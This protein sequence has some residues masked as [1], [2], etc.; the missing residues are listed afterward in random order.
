MSIACPRCTEK[1]L[2]MLMKG[3]DKNKNIIGVLKCAKCNFIFDNLAE[4]EGSDD[5]TENT[6]E[7]KDNMDTFDMT[8]FM[9]PLPLYCKVWYSSSTGGD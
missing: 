8:R 4:E 3:T 6:V 2:V 1:E 9:Y 5:K 7:R